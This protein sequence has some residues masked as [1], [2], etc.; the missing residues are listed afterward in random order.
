MQYYD[1]MCNKWGFNDGAAEPAGADLY[2]Q[3]YVAV[4]NVIL[5]RR[6]S[7]V[8]VVAFNRG[9]MHNGCMILD[10]TPA[11]LEAIPEHERQFGV[12][13]V[14]EEYLATAYDD[15]YY[16]SLTEAHEMG[17]DQYVQVKAVL[18]KRDLKQAIAFAKNPPGEE[19]R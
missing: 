7:Q 4:L 10:V 1:E 9:G 15:A 13:F 8:R 18:T 17:L 3:L 14:L 16:D 2:R 11:F 12:P 19:T 6:G 5:E